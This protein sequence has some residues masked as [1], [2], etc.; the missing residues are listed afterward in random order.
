MALNTP[1]LIDCHIEVE[2]VDIAKG[3]FHINFMSPNK[4]EPILGLMVK[5]IEGQVV[6]VHSSIFDAGVVLSEIDDQVKE[7]ILDAVNNHIKRQHPA[8]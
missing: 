7:C 8:S 5:V 3:Q 6:I 4:Q 2:T 1:R